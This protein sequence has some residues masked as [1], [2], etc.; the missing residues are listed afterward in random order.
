M[1]LITN[2]TLLVRFIIPD[3]SDIKLN[4]ECYILKKMRHFLNADAHKT[5]LFVY[6]AVDI[7]TKIKILPQSRLKK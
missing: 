5:H 3:I 7:G 2:I 1:S 6:E 4:P